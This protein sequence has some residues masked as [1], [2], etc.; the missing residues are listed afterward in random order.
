MIVAIGTNG[1]RCVVWGIAET[2]EEAEAEAV[3]EF[4]MDPDLPRPDLQFAQVSA[5]RASEILA[6]DINAEDLI[7]TVRDGWRVR[8]EFMP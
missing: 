3:T 6:G 4:E 2:K 8:K 5:D 1:L 7:E